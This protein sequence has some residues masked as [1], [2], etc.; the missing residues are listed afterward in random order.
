[1]DIM[2][3]GGER[4]RRRRGRNAYIILRYSEIAVTEH[5]DRGEGERDYCGNRRLQNVKKKKINNRILH[6]KS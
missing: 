2:K 4:L 5:G 3:N 1:M 6:Q